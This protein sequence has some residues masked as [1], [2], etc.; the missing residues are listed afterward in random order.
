MTE[1]DQ[2]P[3]AFASPADST[4]VYCFADRFLPTPGHL[5]G[6]VVIPLTGTNVALNVLANTLFGVAFGSL[7][8]R[9]KLS[10]REVEKKVLFVKS[11]HVVVTFSPDAREDDESPSS[12]EYDIVK[13]GRNL[14]EP[15]VKDIVRATYGRDVDNPQHRVLQFASSNLIK[16]GLM[17][18]QVT[19]RDGIV[20]KLAGDKKTPIWLADRIQ[21]LADQGQAVW[22]AHQA[23]S[24]AE[25]CADRLMS[26]ISAGIASRKAS[27]DDD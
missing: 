17:G 18:E 15:S 27:D 2:A 9:G 23:W 14:K 8:R 22:S 13:F 5:D 4:L 21:P 1:L 3:A 26:E 24:A 12:L 19:H 20:G 7:A 10:L 11:K 6:K 25:P 16:A